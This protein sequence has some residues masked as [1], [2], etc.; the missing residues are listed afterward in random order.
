[1]LAKVDAGGSPVHVMVRVNEAGNYRPA[2]QINS[3]A[4]TEWFQRAVATRRVSMAELPE[5]DFQARLFHQVVTVEE[6]SYDVSIF[7]NDAWILSPTVASKLEKVSQKDFADEL[8]AKITGGQ[9]ARLSYVFPQFE[10]TI[11][12]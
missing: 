8:S 7:E 5:K 2:L 6:W 12:D 1:M 3:L 9:F 4:L 10:Q 11:V